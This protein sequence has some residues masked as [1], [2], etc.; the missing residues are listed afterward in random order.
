MNEHLWKCLVQRGKFLIEKR[1]WDYLIT[2][3]NKVPECG[4]NTGRNGE[5]ECPC[6]MSQLLEDNL[7]EV[8][9]LVKKEYK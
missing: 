6:R 8:I 3:K 5:P 4:C 1:G 7:Q 2:F 9:E